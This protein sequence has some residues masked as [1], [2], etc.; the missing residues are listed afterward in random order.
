MGSCE[1]LQSLLSLTKTGKQLSQYHIKLLQKQNINTAEDFVEADTVDQILAV[2]RDTTYEIKRELLDL[3]VGKVKLKSVYQPNPVNYST[4]I[5]ELDNLL[6]SIGQPFRPGRVWEIIGESDAGKTELLHTLAINFVCRNG[7]NCGILFV[8]TNSGFET[9]R[10]EEIL[11]QRQLDED[12]VDKYLDQ[13]NVVKAISAQSL[14]MALESLHEQLSDR[15]ANLNHVS[16]TKVVLI[17]SLTAC[18]IML[19]SSSN[20]NKGRSFLTELAMI[21][22]KLA[23]EH[24]IAFIVGNLTFVPEDETDGGDDAD[25]NDDGSTQIDSDAW[26]EDCTYLGDYWCSV[27]TLTLALELPEDSHSDGLRLLKVLSN[28]CGASEGSCLLRIT[29]AG[30]I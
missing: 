19:R 14:L 16:R 2:S 21:M 24:G 1:E 7:V 11:Q 9:E 8:D 23:V 10:L 28:S 22:R 17:D 13:I 4:G 26:Q 25:D 15:K 12:A 29:D 5:E 18:F 3:I 6:E 20:R 30:L 27:C